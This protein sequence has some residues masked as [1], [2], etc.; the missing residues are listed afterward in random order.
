VVRAADPRAAPAVPAGDAA[1]LR[2]GN[3]RFGGRLLALLAGAHP[4]VALSP[5][6]ISTAM[7]MVYAGA[8]GATAAQM[9]DA[10][11]FTLRL[12][13]LA[14]AFNGVT[15]SLATVSELRVA[16]ALYGQR[17]QQFR[18]RFLSLL[19]RDYGAGMR[20]VDFKTAPDAA[21]VAINQWVSEQTA[22]RIREVLHRG[23]V[24]DTTRLAI[25]N[26]VYLRAK[27][28]F[29][30]K[31]G[32]TYVSP[33]H[34]PGGTVDVPTM[35][36]AAMFAYLRGEGY[37]A[38]ELPYQGGRL[39]FDILLPDP[40]RLAPLL[41]RLARDGALPLLWGLAPHRAEVA[42]PKLR[43]TTR[44][45]LA[46]ALK[47]LGMPLAFDAARADLSGIAGPPGYLYVQAVVH[48]AYLNVDEAG[49]E[50]AAATGAT[51]GI[52]AAQAPPPLRFIVDRPFA[53]VLRDLASGAVLFAGVVSRP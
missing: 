8:R 46:D 27:W 18:A 3:D 43:L 41:G 15:Q 38:L 44:F 14:A 45:D 6:S 52:S 23:D 9:A 33:F 5:Y 24:T 39:A 13:R 32:G 7:S 50:A 35:H 48:E 19:A 51:V 28:L 31:R 16:N 4:T 37:Q 30:F 49:T 36:Q 34:A 17:G 42:L 40:G 11:D 47:A 25:V 29:A 10:L 22:H 26:A 20:I 2:A 1:A 53:F 12:P 21:R